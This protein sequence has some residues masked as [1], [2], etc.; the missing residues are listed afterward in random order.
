MGSR[1]QGVEFKTLSLFALDE[2][3]LIRLLKETS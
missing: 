1:I 2:G 3:T